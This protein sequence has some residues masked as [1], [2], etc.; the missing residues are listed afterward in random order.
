MIAKRR[1]RKTEL[2]LNTSLVYHLFPTLYK[3]SIFM[4]IFKR[5][6]EKRDHKNLII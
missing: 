3:K 6:K 5:L 1:G 4:S 2:Y